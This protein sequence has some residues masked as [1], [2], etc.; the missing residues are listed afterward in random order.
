[1]T[2]PNVMVIAANYESLRVAFAAAKAEVIQSIISAA[3]AGMDCGIVGLV[4]GWAVSRVMRM[5]GFDPSTKAL[6]VALRIDYLRR[7]RDPRRAWNLVNKCSLCKC[8][9]H[10][11]RVSWRIVQ[12]APNACSTC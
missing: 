1:M 12:C 11:R 4:V 10:N 2:G 6:T 3:M 7:S 5:M 8:I 9:G